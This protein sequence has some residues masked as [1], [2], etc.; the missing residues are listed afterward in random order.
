MA[1]S[2]PLPRWLACLSAS[3]VVGAEISPP[4]P[5][6]TVPWTR[7]VMTK[8]P[9]GSAG[10]GMSEGAEGPP[11]LR[12]QGGPG[13]VGVGMVWSG[14]GSASGFRASGP[15][16]SEKPVPWLNPLWPQLGHSAA[17]AR[18][19]IFPPPPLPLSLPFDTCRL[20]FYHFFLSL[21][22]ASHHVMACVHM[23]GRS[24]SARTT[25]ILSFI[26]GK[27]ISVGVKQEWVRFLRPLLLGSAD[28]G[29][30]SALGDLQ[31]FA[32]HLESLAD[33]LFSN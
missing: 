4:C 24:P 27:L 14:R 8:W 15:H 26:Q 11:A 7:V 10:L 20:C 13:V 3:L 2:W 25:A 16:R 5:C 23:R 31:S 9:G 1:C 29:G 17:P 22:H 21:L 30:L 19:S 33:R 6:F 32:V 18:P 12:G 28:T